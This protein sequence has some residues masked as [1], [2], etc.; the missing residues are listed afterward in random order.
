MMNKVKQTNEKL[1][2]EDL[3]WNSL[4]FSYIDTDYTYVARYKDGQWDDGELTTNS[5]L[6][7]NQA[8]TVFHYGQHCFEGLKAYRTKDGEIQ[9]FRPQENAKRMYKS[10]ERLLMAP[11]PENRFVE[12]VRETVKANEEWVP[13]YESGG[14]LYIRPYLIGTGKKIGVT[15]SDEYVFS[16]FVMPVGPYFPGGLVPSNFMVS[17][18]D[19]AAP[20]GT[21]ASKVGGNYGASLLPG[22]EAKAQGFSDVV[23]LDPATHTK[24]EEVGS[25]NF[26]G[27][28]EDNK[29]VTPKSP[30]ILP[31]ITKFSLLWIAE[32]RLGMDIEETDVY[33]SELDHLKEAGAMGTAAAIAPIGGLQV[34]NDLH[35][36]YS[37]EEAGPVTKQ[38]YDELM[39]IQKGDIE[40]PE[41]WIIKV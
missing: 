24:I 10:A 33:I 32:N 34:N 3:D 13:P 11:F 31:S 28:T 6:E 1:S 15:P 21:G 22:E 19:R 30:S 12:A 2:P 27:V 39:G 23:Y 26:F 20:Q 38:L 18:Y 17:N 5:T 8:A 16:I 29:F 36:F 25:A 40:A 41:G 37:T 7:V 35:V 14:T 4:G 9:L